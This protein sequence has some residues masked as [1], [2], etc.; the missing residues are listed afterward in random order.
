MAVLTHS[1][2]PLLFV[3][4]SQLATL[5]HVQWWFVHK[6]FYCYCASWKLPKS[7]Q[8]FNTPS[9]KWFNWRYLLF[10]IDRPR[11][12]VGWKWL[13]LFTNLFLIKKKKMPMNDNNAALF[14]QVDMCTLTQ[15]QNMYL[16]LWY[17]F[18]LMLSNILAENINDSIHVYSFNF[19][20]FFSRLTWTP[21]MSAT[22]TV[23]FSFRRSMSASLKHRYIE[24]KAWHTCTHTPLNYAW[25]VLALFLLTW[26]FF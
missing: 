15:E 13:F 1:L 6:S 23:S 19:A 16:M 12:L 17:I 2:A 18:K 11:L 4:A 14:P 3:P 21:L 8:H 25:A 24:A 9:D 5:I 22:W 7:A 26:A 10:L 20:S